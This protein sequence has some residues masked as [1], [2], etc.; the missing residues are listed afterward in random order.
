MNGDDSRDAVVG[1]DMPADFSTFLLSLGTTAMVALA[2]A[3]H[4][5]TQRVSVDLPLARYNIELLR[6]LREKTRGNLT[7][8]EEKVLETLLYDLQ[9]AYV[10]AAPR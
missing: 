10:R 4:P 9:L 6:I 8:E 1:V 5:E 3:P 7:V 2:L